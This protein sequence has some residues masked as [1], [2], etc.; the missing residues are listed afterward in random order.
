MDKLK[1]ALKNIDTYRYVVSIIAIYRAVVH[2]I[3]FT[4]AGSNYEQALA[5]R[6]YCIAL[7]V[8]VL[9]NI[10]FKKWITIWS[11]IYVPIC[12]VF[13]HYGYEKHW[14]YDVNKYQYPEVI[15]NGKIV[16]LIWGII[17]IAMVRD[18]IMNKSWKRVKKLQPVIAILSGLFLAFLLI[19]MQEYYDMTFIVVEALG[20]AYVMSDEK[21][22]KIMINAL[23]DGLIISFF[24]VAYKSLRHRPY[25]CERYM[26]YFCN[27]NMAG[28]YLACLVVAIFTR[29]DY[30]WKANIKRWLKIVI[31]TLFYLL[32]GFVCATVLFN[33]TRTTII[34]LL[35]GLFVAL[36]IELVKSKKKRFVWLKYGLA[37]ISLIVLFKPTFL[38]YRYIPAYYAAN[39]D[40]PKLFPGEDM[41]GTK[42][43]FGDSINSKKYTTMES[44][45]RLA[46]GKWGILIDFE[47]KESDKKESTAEKFENAKFDGRDVTNG[48][49]T[50]WKMYLKRMNLMGHYPQHIEMDEGPDPII[51]HAH[52]SY[53]TVAYEYG[54]IQGVIYFVLM[55]YTYIWS[56]IMYIKKDDKESMHMFAFL[57]TGVCVMTQVTEWI[58]R[59]Q[60][61]IFQFLIIAVIALL[62]EKSENKADS[63]NASEALNNSN[64]L[65]DSISKMLKKV[66]RK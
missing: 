58:T 61:I 27:S 53:F 9:I 19:N 65:L 54:V 11:I 16:A 28:T 6:P 46:F 39:V 40:Q 37:L 25:D 52:N 18:M 26:L 38:A 36:I 56:I 32:Q 55:I 14:I 41:L 57:A 42:V 43:M 63:E 31:L 51:Y 62:F 59:P 30:W 64:I 60:Y 66:K 49:V 48:R 15:R 20:I 24:Y 47:G 23:I 45:L 22:R 1:R 21:K 4:N 5:F 12:Y 35:F 33:Y 8:L 17:L 13:T 3:D 10:D 50:I 34:G 7:G 44:Y 2:Y 29:M